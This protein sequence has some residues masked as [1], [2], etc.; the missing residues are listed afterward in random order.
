MTEQGLTKQKIYS[1]ICRSPHGSLKEYLPIGK[2][3]IQTEPEFYQHLVAWSFK[4][5]QIRDSKVALPVL[6]LAY[7]KDAE[8]LD[9]SLAHLAMLNPRELLK[10]FM[11]MR[12]LRPAGRMMTMDRLVRDYLH[13][14]ESEKGWDHVAI[15]HSSVLRSLYS[16]ARVKPTKDRVHAALWGFKGKGENK[17]I[18]PMPNGSVFE[19]V[20]NLK[21]MTPTEAAGAIIKF[22]IPFLI[23]AGALEEKAK[24]PELVLA[25]L[26]RMSPTE[27]VTNVKMLE[28]LGVKTNPA[29]RGAFE[30]AMAKAATSKQNT[31]KTTQA[32]EAVEDEGLK[33]KLRA[34]QKKQI[35][36][37]GGPEGDW[38]VLIDKSGSMSQAIE[39]GRNIAAQLAQF[40]RGKVWMVFFDT[41][42]MTIDVTNLS[43]DQ[44]TA[45]T[46]H[47]HAGGGTSIGCALNRLLQEKVEVDGIAIVSDGGEHNAPLFA[48]V[49]AKYVKFADKDVPVYFYQL[50]GD[51]DYLSASMNAAKIELQTFDLRGSSIDYYS[52]PNLVKS[53]N[54]NQYSLIDSIMATPLV[55]LKDVLKNSGEL[56][57]V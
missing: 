13:D 34:V 51:P 48:D 42:P 19:A 56:V 45:G 6:G 39:T 1:E 12:E 35:A 52:L 30:T 23:A 17:V 3:A 18:L 57:G 43:L 22:K 16:Y 8:L 29:L 46:K 53:M 21:K 49:Y 31:L 27:L 10:G 37:A 15:Q 14:L 54:S 25:M 2:E 20:H 28:K 24:E 40:V 11:F 32:V 44:I 9:N 55:S 41:S 47:I 5:S 33:E 50:A 26:N 4:N 36:A 38:A 7:E